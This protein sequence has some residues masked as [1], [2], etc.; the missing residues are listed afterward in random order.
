MATAAPTF[1]TYKYEGDQVFAYHGKTVIAKGTEFS[2]VAETAEEYFNELRKQ[3]KKRDKE[4]SK[5]EATHVTT[6]N[7]LKG[8]IVSRL[9]TI[10]GDE[11]TVR[12]ANGEIRRYDT[13]VDDDSLVFTAEHANAPKNPIEYFEH[14][15]EEVAEPGRPGLTAR[16]NVLNEIREEAGRL[17]TAGVSHADEQKLHNV[18]LAAEAEKLE[19]KEALDHLEAADAEAYVPPAP[20]QTNVIDQAPMGRAANDSWLDVT[21][22]QMIAES[23]EQDFHKLLEEGPTMLVTELETPALADTGTTAEAAYAH[24]MAKTAGFE[25]AEVEAY[26]EKFVAATELARRAELVYRKDNAHKEAATKEASVENVP[27]EA[28]YF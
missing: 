18:V 9:P 2:K 6:P 14:R 13:A 8:Q 23:E 24:V 5:R 25:G 7:G 17:V 21:A 12:L 11:I 3:N 1:P 20:F 16:L 22:R 10:W 15:L 19:V 27:D 26:R 4:S 28:L